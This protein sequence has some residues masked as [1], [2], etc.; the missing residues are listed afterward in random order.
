MGERL[1]FGKGFLLMKSAP[2]HRANALRNLCAGG[3][4]MQARGRG[5]DGWG[6]EKAVEK[7]PIF[8]A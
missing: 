3:W 4:W 1:H 2:I 8:S 7:Q 6:W 5:R